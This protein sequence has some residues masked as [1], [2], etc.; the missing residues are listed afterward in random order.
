MLFNS[1]DFA[2]FLP[3]VFLLYWFVTN[4][5]LK[6]QNLLLVVSSFVFYGWW[7]WRFL[8]LMGITILLSWLS[9]LGIRYVRYTY[10]ERSARKRLRLI[11]ALNIVINLLI[12]GYFKYYNFFAVSYTLLTLPKKA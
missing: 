11:T 9:G 4:R 7:D 12:L 1:L 8:I 6:L 10:E 3:V 5:N 2:I